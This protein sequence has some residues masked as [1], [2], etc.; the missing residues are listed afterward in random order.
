MVLQNFM[1]IGLQKTIE[2]LIIYL[3]VMEYYLIMKVPRR[4]E[5][6]VTKKII[7]GL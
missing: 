2:K 7:R 6:F 4:G 1:V 5:T 3:L